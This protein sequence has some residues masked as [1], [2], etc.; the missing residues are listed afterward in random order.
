MLCALEKDDRRRESKVESKL[1]SSMQRVAKADSE[2]SRRWVALLSRVWQGD[3][4]FLRLNARRTPDDPPRPARPTASYNTSAFQRAHSSSGTTRIL[5]IQASLDLPGRPW[6]T[7]AVDHEN[8]TGVPRPG[9][10]DPVTRSGRIQMISG[11]A[12]A[13]R[14]VVSLSLPL[15]TLGRGWLS[16]G[17]PRRRE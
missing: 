10:G 5:L 17:C 6:R 8:T 3:R 4:E 14:D 13:W 11:R 7:D 16:Q 1:H 2:L 15:T 12:I 9:H